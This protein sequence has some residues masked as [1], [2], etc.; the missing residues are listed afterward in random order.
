MVVGAQ[1]EPG[2]GDMSYIEVE[3]SSSWQGVVVLSCFD[4]GSDKR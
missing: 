2:H 1:L 3:I 4:S